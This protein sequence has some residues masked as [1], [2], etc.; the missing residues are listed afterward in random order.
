MHPRSRC[1][2]IPHEIP[3]DRQFT[4]K[5]L[6]LKSK[7]SGPISRLRAAAILRVH[8]QLGCTDPFPSPK[9]ALYS[10]PSKLQLRLYDG[11]EC[12]FDDHTLT[13]T[14]TESFHPS[15][16]DITH[17][18]IDTTHPQNLH[19][20]PPAS[21]LRSRRFCFTTRGILFRY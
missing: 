15:L 13:H 18:F 2:P 14:I 21:R 3:D 1:V 11:F 7:G 4:R 5:I 17:T 9:L 6:V 12:S 8:C 19:A 16:I 20:S 10:V